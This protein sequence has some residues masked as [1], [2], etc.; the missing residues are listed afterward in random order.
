MSS[1]AE[2]SVLG[3]IGVLR[4]LEVNVLH[5]KKAIPKKGINTNFITEADR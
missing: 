5:K 1:S 4:V 2:D 3:E